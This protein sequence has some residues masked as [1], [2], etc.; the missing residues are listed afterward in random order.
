MTLPV[1]INLFWV[2]KLKCFLVS[3]TWFSLVR[4]YRQLNQYPVFS[5]GSKGDT[6]TTA[7]GSTSPPV[8][9]VLKQEVCLSQTDF[10]VKSCRSKTQETSE[11]MKS[12]YYKWHGDSQKPCWWWT[13]ESPGLNKYQRTGTRL[14]DAA[15]LMHK[16]QSK[17]RNVSTASLQHRHAL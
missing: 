6:T 5:D 2:F 17:Y 8:L 15:R 10:I 12:V 1:D 4:N 16:K 9:S 3:V 14:Q 13:H 11:C 7:C